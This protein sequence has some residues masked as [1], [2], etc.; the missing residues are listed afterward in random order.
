[1]AEGKQG[2]D[3]D[4]HGKARVDHQPIVSTE[5]A[6]DGELLL[7]SGSKRTQIARLRSLRSAES[8]LRIAQHLLPGAFRG[9]LT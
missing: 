9:A 2:E 6:K 3:M 5:A 7:R 4:G 8:G 1:M